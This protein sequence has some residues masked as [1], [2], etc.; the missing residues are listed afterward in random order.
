M[1]KEMIISLLLKN[2]KQAHQILEIFEDK[3]E[4]NKYYKALM[5]EFDDTIQKA[6]KLVNT[7]IAV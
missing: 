7:K 2:L 3:E 5:F 6:E 4:F 1:K